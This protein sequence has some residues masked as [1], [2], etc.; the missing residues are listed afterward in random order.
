MYNINQ[1]DSTSPLF[2]I[3]LPVSHF[4][5]IEVIDQEIIE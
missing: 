3:V 2:H 1:N 5:T 4:F